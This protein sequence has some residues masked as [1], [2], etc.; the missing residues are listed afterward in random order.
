MNN[1]SNVVISRKD[2]K[3]EDELYQKVAQQ[4]R[5]LLESG[6]VLIAEDV[7]PRGGT[8]V[9]QY[10]PKDN[11]STTPKPFWLLP[12][13]MVSAAD[14]HMTNEVKRA[15]DILTA[16]EQANSLT[17]LFNDVDLTMLP[18]KGGNGK[19]GKGGKGDA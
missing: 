18:K 8:I 13:E 3:N 11:E 19:G 12:N 5:I 2:Y 7:E 6:Y 14:T 15:R 16:A 9:I 10:A 17:N 1:V 4:I